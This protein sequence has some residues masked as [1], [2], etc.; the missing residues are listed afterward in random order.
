[1][2]MYILFLIHALH[3][4]ILAIPEKRQSNFDTGRK[5]LMETTGRSLHD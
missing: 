5:G 4:Y 1:M 3:T 2:S